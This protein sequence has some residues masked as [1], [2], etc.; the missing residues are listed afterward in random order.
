MIVAVLLTIF[1]LLLFSTT[2]GH[3]QLKTTWPHTHTP[4]QQVAT[5]DDNHGDIGKLQCMLILILL[6]QN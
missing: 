2:G 1:D 3:A 4:S 6:L 5:Q